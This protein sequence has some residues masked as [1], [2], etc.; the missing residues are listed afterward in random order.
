VH[1]LADAAAN[2][3]EATMPPKNAVAP[4]KIADE[5][6][7]VAA[8]I[9]RCPRQM[10]LRELVMNAVEAASVATGAPSLV[11]I[12]AETID[13][14]PKLSI[15]NTGPGLSRTELLKISDLSSSLFKTVGLDGNFGMGA[16]VA[17]LT[18]N[19]LGLRYRS[20]KNGRVSQII[21]GQRDGI[22]GRVV[23]RAA[24][25]KYTE[26]LDVTDIV[27]AEGRYNLAH[28]WTEVLLMGN[29]AGQN[30]VL[31][32]YDGD[33]VMAT[34]WVE[35]T[36]G[37]R[38]LKIDPKVE[39]RIG[40]EVGGTSEPVVFA[41][42]LGPEIFDRMQTV[43]LDG[44]ICIHYA[45]RSPTSSK[46]AP[47]FESVGIGM[48]GHRD[49]VY[50]LSPLR[51]WVLEAPTCGFTFAAR[52]C[53][54]LVELSETYPVHPEQYRQFLRFSDGDQHQ[55]QVADFGE[56]IRE[57]IPGW[58]KAI[59]ASMMPDAG[60][61]ISEI[62]ADLQQLLFQ[63]GIA[64]EKKPVVKLPEDKDK[65]KEKENDDAEE[66]KPEPPVPPK[67][68][69]PTPP[70]IILI[71]DETDIVDKGLA[72]RVARFY[73]SQRQLFVNARYA[74]FARMA[75]QLTEEFSD[76]VDRATAEA[77]SRPAAEW[78]IVSR[79]SRAL[80]YSL[81]KAKLGWGPE[82]IRTIQSPEAM[83]LL[84]DDIDVLMGP[85]R[86]RL[87]LQ[88]G[89]E[90]GSG[91]ASGVYADE[92]SGHT[93]TMAERNAGDLAD[94]E[95]RLQRAMGATV[96]QLGPHYKN[97]AAILIRQRQFERAREFLNMGIAADPADPW[98][99]LEM[100]GLLMAE[101]NLKRAAWSCKE[102]LDRSGDNPVPF[103]MRMGDIQ[104]RQGDF[105]GAAQTFERAATERPDSSWI[106][107]SLSTARMMQGQ[108]DA[109][110]KAVRA[111]IDISPVANLGHLRRLSE[112]ERLRGNWEG[113][114][115]H[116]AVARKMDPWD[117]PTLLAS[118]NLTQMTGSHSKAHA[119]VSGYLTSHPAPPA[120]V[121]CKLS[122]L[123]LQ[124]GH[125]AEALAA[126]NRACSLDASDA[127][128]QAQRATVFLT[129]GDL[130]GAMDAINTAIALSAAPNTNLLRRKANILIRKSQYPEA[131]T[132]L[133]TCLKLAPKDAFVWFDLSSL[134]VALGNIEAAE[135]AV[136][137]GE[138]FNNGSAVYFLRRRAELAFRKGAFGA[139]L[140]FLIRA[141]EA[142]PLNPLGLMD[143]AARLFQAGDQTEAM[144]YVQK[145][146]K[147]GADKPSAALLRRAANL[148][149]RAG[150][151]DAAKALLQRALELY[152]DD[153]Q[154]WADLANL[155][156]Q[157]GDLGAAQMAAETALER[158]Q[159][160]RTKIKSVIEQAL[161]S[162]A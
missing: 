151:Y 96:M 58:L 115:R 14:T 71:E 51:R 18:S 118:V 122:E 43:A 100:A 93:P 85:A 22:Y 132:I 86:A 140:G 157:T 53:T 117:A 123:E 141:H 94:A 26:V 148:H 138:R 50:A 129:I 95:A 107:F 130:D 143:I 160:A 147:L 75:A 72:G 105:E 38:F 74:A 28:D 144:K 54:V 89:L 150:D 62:K 128:A 35:K 139:G 83:S 67:P 70:E 134:E 78:A 56:L 57:N 13:D 2:P 69:L 21:L 37:S 8:T 6:F 103:L 114:R 126:A 91:H 153:S 155:L 12:T 145:A 121:L 66:K 106:G 82:E 113:A 87:A 159:M 49:E 24:K 88:L 98:C 116:L 33:P 7:L 29:S 40:A 124:L 99:H 41:P 109:A 146:L 84:V 52:Q 59:I 131:R 73:P 5:G 42:E 120:S 46:R 77:Q 149:Q 102:A 158:S 136:A 64:D 108:L 127:A 34:G 110:E 27:T 60:D 19:K 80:A 44:G 11:R 63:L 161:Q 162:I 45:Y 65:D 79:L 10:M 137:T 101:G 3:K 97:I 39:I 31:D 15:W 55:V 119:E 47:R 104:I 32:P 20:C 61:Y 112:I 125:A 154:N 68:P 92:M 135:D 30:T 16:K 156:S 90:I 152:P 76:Q 9:E 36:L 48:V 25:G 1:I 133:E 111:A 23:Q 4:L 17:S 142:D 81:G